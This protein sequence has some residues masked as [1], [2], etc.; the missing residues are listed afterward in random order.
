MGSGTL[1]LPISYAGQSLGVWILQSQGVASVIAPRLEGLTRVWDPSHDPGLVLCPTIRVSALKGK[2]T[3]PEVIAVLLL[4][5][6]AGRGFPSK[7]CSSEN[8]TG[9]QETPQSH[10]LQHTSHK[11]LTGRV[12]PRRVLFLLR[13]EAAAN[14][15]EDRVYVGFLKDQSFPGYNIHLSAGAGIPLGGNR[16]YN[17]KVGNF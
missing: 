16:V 11:R 12:K 10:T 8:V 14:R 9:S 13:Q 6:P 1:A 5:L 4:P 15:T 17:V 3:P 2:G 7:F